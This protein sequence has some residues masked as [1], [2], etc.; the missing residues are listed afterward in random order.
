MQERGELSL[1]STGDF[2]SLIRRMIRMSG[3]TAAQISR[4]MGKSSG[5]LS[6]VLADKRIPRT[7]LLVK[8]ASACGYHVEIYGGIPGQFTDDIMLHVDD[9]GELFASYDYSS[10]END[11]HDARVSE[12]YFG[13]V[14]PPET[15]S[16]D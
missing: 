3:K 7:D 4:E 14:S 15:E 12:L 10:L 13:H 16:I 6:V 5:Y 1:E 11:R 8:I 2:Q 9:R